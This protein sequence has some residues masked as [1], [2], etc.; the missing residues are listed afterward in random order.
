MEEG[1]LVGL[2]QG[3]CDVGCLRLG[4][5]FALLEVGEEFAGGGPRS[6]G[7]G[8]EGGGKGEAQPWRERG[9]RGRAWEEGRWVGG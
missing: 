7:M 4:E 9:W 2:S 3:V 5:G 8:G 1:R 6:G